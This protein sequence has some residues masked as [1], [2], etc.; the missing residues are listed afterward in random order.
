MDDE[1]SDV[2]GSHPGRELLGDDFERAPT[3]AVDAGHEDHP[4]T[5]GQTP[6]EPRVVT[7]GAVI[8]DE[9]MCSLELVRPLG[10]IT[11]RWSVRA[12]THGAGTM[13]SELGGE[14]R[15]E[16]AGSV[17]AAEGEDAERQNLLTRLLPIRDDQPVDH[18]LAT[19]RSQ[20]GSSSASR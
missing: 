18:D 6:F 2:A 14:A 7:R 20:P 13:A 11:W 19:R 1:Q 5:V 4:V 8:D 16:V 3:G 10:P 9:A 12:G 17:H 15:Q